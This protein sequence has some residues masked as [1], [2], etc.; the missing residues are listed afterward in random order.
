MTSLPTRV[1][2]HG[3]EREASAMEVNRA[4]GTAIRIRREVAEIR[5]AAARLAAGT[6]AEK[7]VAD[8]LTVQATMLERAGGTPQRADGMR[9]D[10]DTV[11][12]PGQFPSPARSALLIARAY[13]A[14]G[15]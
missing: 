14:T 15:G 10:D 12:Q 6:T 11:D 8:F 7:A 1:D 13:L 2:S 9:L 3:N 5:A 4:E